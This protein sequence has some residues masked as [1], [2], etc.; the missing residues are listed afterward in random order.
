MDDKRYVQVGTCLSR[1]VSFGISRAGIEF[2]DS[3]ILC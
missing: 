3:D 1:I 2:S